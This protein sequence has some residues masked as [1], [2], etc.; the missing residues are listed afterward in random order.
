MRIFTKMERKVCSY[1]DQAAAD[2]HR[3]IA[4]DEPEFA[5]Y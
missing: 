1:D 2:H 5:T 3:T 4:H